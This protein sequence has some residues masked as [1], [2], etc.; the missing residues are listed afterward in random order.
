[1]DRRKGVSTGPE[2]LTL[3]EKVVA[4]TRLSYTEGCIIVGLLIGSPGYFLA[5]LLETRSPARALDLLLSNP[6]FTIT[7]FGK[8]IPVIQSLAESVVWTTFLV[9]VLYFTRYMRVKVLSAE[10]SLEKLVSKDGKEKYHRAFGGIVR[11]R[12][13]IPFIAGFIVL[14]VPAR[15]AVPSAPSFWS[16]LVLLPVDFVF[17]G[18]GLWIY[19]R[20]LWGVYRFGKEELNLRPF[21]EDRM[22]GLRPLGSISLSFTVVF[23]TLVV[24]ALAGSFIS[25]DLS[26]LA[27]QF[28]LLCLLAV[29]LFLPL[30]GVHVKMV[31]EKKRDQSLMGDKIREIANR[32]ERELNAGGDEAKTLLE[33]DTLLTYRMLKEEASKTP[34]WPFDTRQVE[35]LVALLLSVVGVIIA[36]LIQVAFHF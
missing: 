2:H 6:F 13:A 5:L 35:R 20:A 16:A 32:Q 25:T 3:T 31:H 10:P 11:A 30:N 22:L 12:N 1:M 26:N 23:L 7:E 24:T 17:I 21:Y 4:L 8:Q 19:L 29:M 27:V 36:R 34:T 14:Y 15:L 28:C 33:I 9:M 18:V